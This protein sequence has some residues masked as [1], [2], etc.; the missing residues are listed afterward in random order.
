MNSNTPLAIHMPAPAGSYKLTHTVEC[1]RACSGDLLSAASAS[2]CVTKAIAAVTLTK[3]LLAVGGN[4]HVASVLLL[5]LPLLC[6][7]ITINRHCWCCDK[8]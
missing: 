5:L 1:Q 6:G 2:A 3:H 7:S 8:G 4:M